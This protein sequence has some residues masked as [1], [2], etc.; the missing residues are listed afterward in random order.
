[1]VAA[2]GTPSLPGSG[3]SSAALSELTMSRPALSI[4]STTT[5]PSIPAAR[6][7]FWTAER[8]KTTFMTPTVGAFAPSRMDPATETDTRFADSS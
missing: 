1:V 8:P 5:S 4:T 2:A 7:A 6:T 3:S